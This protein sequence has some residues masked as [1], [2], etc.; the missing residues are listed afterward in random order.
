M[1]VELCFTIM[2]GFCMSGYLRNKKQKRTKC[3]ELCT[4]WR[5]AGPSINKEGD[6]RDGDRGHDG[7]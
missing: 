2:F 4:D 3:S 5:V 6:S 7:G 1:E